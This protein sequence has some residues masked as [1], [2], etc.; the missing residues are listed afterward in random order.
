MCPDISHRA[1]PT[2]IKT[3]PHNDPTSRV[4]GGPPIWPL[5]REQNRADVP[6]EPTRHTHC[7]IEIHTFMSNGIKLQSPI[8]FPL[9]RLE[10]SLCPGISMQG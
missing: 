8:G 2:A 9:M 4:L 3:G 5:W 10:H 1:G 6:P 7:S